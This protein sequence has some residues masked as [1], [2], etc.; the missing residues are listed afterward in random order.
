MKIFDKQTSIAKRLAYAYATAA[1]I[2]LSIIVIGLYCI[3]ISEI[4]RYQ[5]AEMKNRIAL[6]EHSVSDMNTPQEWQHLKQTLQKLTPPDSDIY[7]RISSPEP[8]FNFEAPFKVDA[9]LINKHSGF[10]KADINGR[11]FRILSRIIPAQGQRPQLLLSIAVETYLNETEDFLLD[12]AFGIFLLFG[13]IAIAIIGWKI[14]K[15]SLQPVDMLSR[16]ARALSPQNLSARLPNTN[17]PDE[18]SGLVLSF[19]GALERLEESYNKLSTFSSDVAHELRTPLGNLIGQTEVALSRPRSKEELED[20]MHSNLEELERLRTIINEMLF[21]SRADHGE[22]ATNLKP[23]SLAQTV[24]ETAEFLE[25]ILEESGHRLH[26]HGDVV[27]LVEINLFKQ[28]ITNLIT[29]AIQHGS[30]QS[31]IKVEISATDTDACIS[32]INQGENISASELNQIF[33]RFYRVSK[34]RKNS[35]SNHGLGLAIVKAIANMHGGEV[36]AQSNNHTIT[37]GFTLPLRPVSAAPILHKA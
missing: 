24:R 34:E 20:V 2:V 32:V 35:V 4:N 16:H 13:T 3:E 21:L 25:V 6:L 5:K 11:E 1:A 37:I 14:A 17:L 29:N 30:P 28:A 19:N 12:L 31:D 33:N 26:I 23:A 15:T 8:N 10:S 18:L 22:L 27:T 9:S 7:I 36:F